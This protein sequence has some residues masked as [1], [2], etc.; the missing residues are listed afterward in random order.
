MEATQTGND[1]PDPLLAAD[2]RGEEEKVILNVTRSTE[3]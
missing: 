3:E 2:M 1:F